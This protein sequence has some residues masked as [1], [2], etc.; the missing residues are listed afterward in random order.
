MM[1]NYYVTSFMW[2]TIAK[3]INALLNFISLPILL[4]QFGVD[5]Y[6]VLTLAIATNAYM[7]LLDLG[8]N[9]GSIKHFA[10]WRERKRFDLIKRVAGT[11]ISFYGIIGI[12]NALLLLLIAFWGSSWFQ[13]TPEQFA[14]YRISLFILAGFV[15]IN[16]SSSVFVQLLTAAEKISYIQRL[17]ILKTFI[18][19]GLIWITVWLDL[20]INE[21]FFFFTLINSALFIPYYVLSRRI[22]L[23][24]QWR[25]L[26]YWKD[27]RRVLKYSLAIFVMAVFQA[28][29]TQS[30]LIVLGF[31]AENAATTLAEYRI[32]EVFP[33][34][35]L[36]I[37]GAM[38]GILLPKSARH[39]ARGDQAAIEKFAYLGTRYTSIMT[40]L[41]CIPIM[42]CAHELISVYVGPSFGDLSKWMKLWIFT[43]L[44]NLYNSPIS[45]LILA[46][47]RTRML[48]YSSA[49]ACIISIIVNVV[50][51]RFYGV[52]S[53]VIGYLIY[54]LIQQGFYYCYFNARVMNLNSWTVFRMFIVP[55]GIGLV[56]FLFISWLD[57]D[58]ASTDRGYLILQGFLK[59]AIWLSLFLIT[60]CSFNVLRLSDMKNWMMSKSN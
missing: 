41:I 52:G 2:S 23:I 54:I 51:C 40:T 30:R 37:C 16:W 50:L 45:S 17:N 27:F 53:A 57:I 1:N 13:L 6:G 34:F 24:D 44:L 31:V 49:I 19:F 15:I 28:T 58:F 59:S 18:A 47:G 25:P 21:Y 35:I 8:I 10:Q 7:S 20:T 55:T 12:L 3:L 46:T 29:A 38:I 36:S 32:I 60:I 4:R 56:F 22:G 42:L 33:L 43:L 14:Q 39:I 5:N 11:S 26:F 9:T 48:V